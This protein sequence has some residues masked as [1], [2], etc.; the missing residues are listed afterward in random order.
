MVRIR[1]ESDEIDTLLRYGLEKRRIMAAEDYRPVLSF[2]GLGSDTTA[3]HG[4]SVCKIAQL[5]NMMSSTGITLYR[6]R[7]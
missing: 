3:L 4:G 7:C 6:K 5:M 1:S 2:V